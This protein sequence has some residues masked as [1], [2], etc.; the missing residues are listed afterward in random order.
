VL[1]VRVRILKHEFCC[2]QILKML[3]FFVWIS[4]T[5]NDVSVL[6]KQDENL[7]FVK[8]G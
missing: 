8:P 3:Q 5:S 2:G 7:E 6:G 1:W 4:I